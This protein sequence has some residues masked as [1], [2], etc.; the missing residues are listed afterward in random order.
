MVNFR[1]FSWTY[2]DDILVYRDLA[3]QG[4]FFNEIKPRLGD[5]SITCSDWLGHQ[6]PPLPTSFDD[7]IVLLHK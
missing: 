6:I 3:S 2:S 1:Y 7:L 4:R 5:G